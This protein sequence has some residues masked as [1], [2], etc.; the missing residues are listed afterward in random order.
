[1]TFRDKIITCTY[2]VA[3]AG[4][5]FGATF[6]SVVLDWNFSFLKERGNNEIAFALALLVMV[7]FF[8]MAYCFYTQNLTKK[9]LRKFGIN[10][11]LLAVLVALSLI[12]AF[13]VE[14]FKIRL[15][16][17]ILFWIGTLMVKYESVVLA[18]KRVIRLKKT[19]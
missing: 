12:T 10:I 4:I 6:P 5:L 16:Y 19:S 15:F 1:M 17:F 3:W 14:N 9:Q 7:Q 11:C 13:V 8:E 18:K 2:V